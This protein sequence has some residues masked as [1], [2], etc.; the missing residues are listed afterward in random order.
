MVE[1]AERIF[2][3]SSLSLEAGLEHCR[4]IPNGELNSDS[5]FTV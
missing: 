5:D 3:S 4:V 2:A 1:E